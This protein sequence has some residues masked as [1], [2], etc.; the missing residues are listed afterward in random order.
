MQGRSPGS[1]TK[2]PRPPLPPCSWGGMSG[3]E[4]L[5]VSGRAPASGRSSP[6]F[7]YGATFC[8]SVGSA[9]GAAGGLPPSPR[10]G[11]PYR[12]T[13]SSFRRG[14]ADSVTRAEG[15]DGLRAA[16]GCSTDATRGCPGDAPGTVVANEVLLGALPTA[17]RASPSVSPTASATSVS[18]SPARRRSARSVTSPTPSWAEVSTGAP[19][20]GGGGGAPPSPGPPSRSSVVQPPR[21]GGA[22]PP[23]CC[24][25]AFGDSTPG[26]SGRNTPRTPGSPPLCIAPRRAPRKTTGDHEEAFEGEARRREV[27]PSQCLT[28]RSAARMFEQSSGRSTPSSS[29][30]RADTPKRT[31]LSSEELEAMQ[32]EA[33]RQEVR[34]LLERNARA[35]ERAAA[36]RLAPLRSAVAAAREEAASAALRHAGGEG[37]AG[38]PSQPVYFDI[39]GECE[40]AV[41]MQTCSSSGSRSARRSP[42]IA[43]A[44]PA[45]GSAVPSSPGCVRRLF[46]QPPPAMRHNSPRRCR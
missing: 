3:V 43:L 17:A 19:G 39:G 22:P 36:Q 10:C 27:R 24:G 8:V 5:S 4:H 40:D 29:R 28:D 38:T 23:Q 46:G 20:P 32:V 37:G 12:S 44:S 7:A 34:R 18:A 14:R 2:S 21:Q 6:R 30:Q 45:A 33:K 16:A 42:V 15:E 35:V 11:S 31:A 13:R 9:G 26:R 25:N 1:G 41:P